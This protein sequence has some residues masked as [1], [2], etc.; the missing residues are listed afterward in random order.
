MVLFR[1]FAK[2]CATAWIIQ[3]I[4]IINVLLLLVLPV[5]DVAVCWHVSYLLV[6]TRLGRIDL[7]PF[8]QSASGVYDNCLADASD[9]PGKNQTYV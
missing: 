9:P 4:I 5:S 1:A 8:Y 2:R 3:Y 6:A 7:A